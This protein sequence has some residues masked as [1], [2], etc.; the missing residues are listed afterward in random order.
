MHQSEHPWM[1]HTV[2][3]HR[4]QLPDIPYWRANGWEPCDGPPPE[5]DLTRAPIDE[6]P[7]T[8]AGPSASRSKKTASPDEAG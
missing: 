2:T 8:E 1:Q 5:P 4:A 3:G 6:A 7:P